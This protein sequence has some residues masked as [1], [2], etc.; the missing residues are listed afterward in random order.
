MLVLTRKVDQSI[1][2]HNPRT[3]D[4]VEVFVTEVRGDQ[5]RLVD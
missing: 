1:V 3:G 2:I 4:T 5:V